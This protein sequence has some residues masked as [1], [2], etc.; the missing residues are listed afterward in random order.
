MNLLEI[1]H[2]KGIAK[3]FSIGA[4]LLMVLAGNLKFKKIILI[5]PTP[6]VNDKIYELG[7]IEKLIDIKKSDYSIKE[8][9]ERIDCEVEVYIGENEVDLMKETALEISL[10]LGVPLN[11][12]KNADHSDILDKMTND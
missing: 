11:V 6:L 7:E 12:I 4:Y 10:V 1:D 3:G 5:S 2:E 9:C 8:L